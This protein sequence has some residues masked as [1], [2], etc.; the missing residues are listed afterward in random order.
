MRTTIDINEH[1]FRDAKRRATS[2]AKTLREI[3]ECALR[4]YLSSNRQK[5]G[6]YSLRWRTETGRVQPGVRLDDRDALFDLMD[7]RS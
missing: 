5:A 4:A 1:L 7:G 2:E 3:V 6:A